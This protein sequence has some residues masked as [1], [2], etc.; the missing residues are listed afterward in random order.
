VVKDNGKLVLLEAFTPVPFLETPFALDE[1]ALEKGFSSSVTAVLGFGTVEAWKQ[2]EEPLPPGKWKDLPWGGHEGKETL[3]YLEE[4]I[5]MDEI[6]RICK[7]AGYKT[8]SCPTQSSWLFVLPIL[9][10]EGVFR[11]LPEGLDPE[12]LVYGIDI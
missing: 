5:S 11:P 8:Q 10:A 12:E 2:T 4:P 3:Y 6:S 1:S 9:S 7:K